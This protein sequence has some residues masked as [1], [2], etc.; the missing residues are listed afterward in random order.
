MLY[1]HSG[2]RLLTMEL[3]HCLPGHPGPRLAA[4]H[5]GNR[6]ASRRLAPPVCPVSRLSVLSKSRLWR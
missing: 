1:P 4:P 2:G 5:T 3:L 6:V